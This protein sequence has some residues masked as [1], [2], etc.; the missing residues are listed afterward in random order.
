[1]SHAS[2]REPKQVTVN[3]AVLMVRI[4]VTVGRLVRLVARSERRS[5]QVVSGGRRHRSVPAAV[6]QHFDAVGQ[7][8]SLTTT[9]GE[10]GAL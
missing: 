1:M 8:E 4:G 10:E 2:L 7:A 6:E 5:V 9:N 3:L